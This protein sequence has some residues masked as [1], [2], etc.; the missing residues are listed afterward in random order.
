VL[1]G[2]AVDADRPAVPESVF[3]AV[4][5]RGAGSSPPSLIVF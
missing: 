1:L 4:S 5:V 2:L 3:A